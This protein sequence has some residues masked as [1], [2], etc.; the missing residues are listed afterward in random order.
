M[1]THRNAGRAARARKWTENTAWRGLGGAQPAP[2]PA[3]AAPYPHAG[4]APR[5]RTPPGAAQAPPPAGRGRHGRRDSGAVRHHHCAAAQERQ[6]EKRRFPLPRRKPA[7]PGWWPLCPYGGDGASTTVQ[8]VNWGHRRPAEAGGQLHHTA[9]PAQPDAVPEFGRVSTSWFADAAL[10]GDSLT[11]GFCVNEY[12]I[13]VGGALVCGYEGV[14]PNTI[15]NRTTATSPDRGEGGS[16][17]RAFRRTARQAV[18]PY[19]HQCAGAA[20]QR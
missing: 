16:A 19:R 17:G 13:D 8:A 6:R 11:A 1:P 14:S 7:P 5:R 4:A 20:R 3:A 18:Y 9:L 12:N 2:G 15:V 10:L